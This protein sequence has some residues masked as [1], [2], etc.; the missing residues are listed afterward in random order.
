MNVLPGNKTRQKKERKKMDRKICQGF[1]SCEMLLWTVSS[2][3]GWR[4]RSST[5]GGSR[6]GAWQT[7]PR[8]GKV[9]SQRRDW[10]ASVRLPVQLDLTVSLFSPSSLSS[11]LS[12]P[13]VILSALAQ[14]CFQWT[15]SCPHESKCPRQPLTTEWCFFLFSHSF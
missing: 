15:A 3:G 7:T 5:L 14:A 10:E 12:S 2:T 11:S 13:P 1:R 6:T 8:P 4:F 9:L